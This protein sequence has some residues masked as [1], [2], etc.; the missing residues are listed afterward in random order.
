M[1]KKPKVN[2]T[3]AVRKYLAAH[4][5]AKSGEIAAALTKQG[6]K[7]TPSHAAN[8][9]TKIKKTRTAKKAAVVEVAA[10]T[11]VEKPVKAGDSVTIEQVRAV[12]QAV[13]VLGGA[14]RLNCLLASSRKSAA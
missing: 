14:D 10:P 8:I 7:I 6:I 5:E 11:A 4:P 13:K 9:K 2:K 3:E 1:T 12:A